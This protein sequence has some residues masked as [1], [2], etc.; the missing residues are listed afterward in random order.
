MLG[1]GAA[2]VAVTVHPVHESDPFWQMT[3]GR[4]V[5]AHGARTFAEPVAFGDFTNPAVVPEW[6]FSV[7]TY[8]LYTAGTGRRS[9]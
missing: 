8:V 7:A 6:L 2:S 1:L 5:L 3:L 9:R 4:G